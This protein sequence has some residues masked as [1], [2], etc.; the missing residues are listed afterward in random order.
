MLKRGSRGQAVRDLQERLISQ[1][2]LTGDPDGVFG[3]HT[4]Q[5]VTAFQSD[6]GLKPDGIAGPKTWA[7]LTT[8]IS[9]EPSR[10]T[11]ATYRYFGPNVG[12]QDR[13]TM[14][15][16]ETALWAARMC[17]GEEGSRCSRERASAMLWAVMN[18]WFLHPAAKRNWASYLFLMR[19]FSQPI[20]PRWQKGGDLARKYAG[21]KYCTPAKLRHRAYIS[22]LLW[23]DIPDEVV[24]AV[25]DF[26][27]GILPP[28]ERVIALDK[29]RISNWASHEGLEEK[30]PGGISFA[31]RGTRNWFFEDVNL[32]R[33][34][35]VVDYW[36]G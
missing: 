29:S 27:S 22:A 33:G 32:V 17:V 8:D 15:D 25:R 34:R 16:E 26:Q 14:I 21:T 28:P 12:I 36:N 18:R 23:E 1:G 9:I 3:Q 6:Q 30:Y 5:A 11:L 4:L 7:A 13:S 2:H 19:R 20:N 10:A 24:K 35:V 31:K